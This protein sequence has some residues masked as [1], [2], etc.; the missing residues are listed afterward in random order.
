MKRESMKR[1]NFEY[2]LGGLLLLIL[3]VAIS[4]EVGVKVETRRLFLEPALCLMLLMGIW[5]LG[6][7]KKWLLVGGVILAI[8]GIVST[9]INL[10]LDIPELL[11]V[12]IGIMFVFT[13]AS[14]WIASRHL[15]LSGAIDLNKIIGA[16]CTYLLLGLNWALSYLFINFAIPESFHG[17][18]STDLR[19]QFAELLYYSFVTITT[20]GYGDL[21]PVRPLARTLAYLEA[22]VGQFYV[23]V[24][25]AWLVGMYLSE[26]NQ[27]RKN[28]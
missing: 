6:T 18:T 4:Q 1:V 26:K 22:I 2:L 10:F 21:T 11:L 13:L 28:P 27:H 7:E 16:I 17:L 9:T 12:N 24:L 5:S 15:L 23:A 25:V 20:L 14:T 19:T 3:A 8:S